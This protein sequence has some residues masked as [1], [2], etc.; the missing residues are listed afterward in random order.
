M[1]LL[2]FSTVVYLRLAAIYSILDLALMYLMAPD[3]QEL[4]K[5]FDKH[6][7]FMVQI[8]LLTFIRLHRGSIQ[9]LN[10]KMLHNSDVCTCNLIIEMYDVACGPSMLART[11]VSAKMYQNL[12][13]ISPHD[14]WLLRVTLPP[15]L[16]SPLIQGRHARILLAVA[17]PLST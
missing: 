4:G 16:L 12:G 6:N 1:T 5:S 8:I 17:P 3:Y 13:I 14:L 15:F 10:S 11:P 7:L 2:T 9:I